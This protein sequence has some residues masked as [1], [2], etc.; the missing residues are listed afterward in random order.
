ML[1]L[2]G[3]AGTVRSR[4]TTHRP[5]PTE[6]RLDK[7]DGVAPGRRGSQVFVCTLFWMVLQRH[8]VKRPDAV[9]TEK[10]FKINLPSA[11]VRSVASCCAGSASMLAVIAW[12]T[13]AGPTERRQ[14]SRFAR[15]AP[16][17]CGLDGAPLARRSL[18]PCDHGCSARLRSRGKRSARSERRSMTTSARS[19]S[20]SRWT[21]KRFASW[22][23][24]ACC[25]ARSSLRPAQKRQVLA[26]PVL[27]RSGAL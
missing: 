23:Q 12:E 16:P 5:L 10:A 27:Y 21:R 7:S 22:G 11:I 15:P 24:K 6:R 17:A 19:P 1:R 4:S 18:L 8:R 3:R 25:C 2:K 14:G 20:A 13:A 26:C 9:R